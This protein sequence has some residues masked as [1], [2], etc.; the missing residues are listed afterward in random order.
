MSGEEVALDDECAR[1]VR[2]AC[3]A[4]VLREALITPAVIGG[5]FGL[6]EVRRLVLAVT[7]DLCRSG[8]C[9]R[10]G[11]LNRNFDEGKESFTPSVGGIRHDVATLLAEYLEVG[12]ATLESFD[13]SSP[14][15]FCGFQK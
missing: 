15:V 10:N 2:E 13:V 4:R 6:R 3:R 11:L 1:H 14:V 5:G 9:S 8:A 12:G 7:R